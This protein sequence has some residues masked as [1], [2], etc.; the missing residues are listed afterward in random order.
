ME[1]ALHAEPVPPPVGSPARNFPSAT[2]PVDPFG[3]FPAVPSSSVCLW[4]DMGQCAYHYTQHDDYAFGIMTADG[5]MLW[6]VGTL[7]SSGCL[8]NSH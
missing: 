3:G 6:H 4:V 2:L 7:P 1:C 8:Y 5:E